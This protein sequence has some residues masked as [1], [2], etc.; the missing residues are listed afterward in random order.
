MFMHCFS[1]WPGEASQRASG[2]AFAAN[3]TTNWKMCTT[4]SCRRKCYIWKNFLIGRQKRAT[5]GKQIK[6]IRN[7]TVAGIAQPPPFWSL[8]RASYLVGSAAV[9]RNKHASSYTVRCAFLPVLFWSP[10]AH[11]APATSAAH[12]ACIPLSHSLCC[13]SQTASTHK[14]FSAEHF[15]SYRMLLD[16]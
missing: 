5:R 16:Y 9:R 7:P 12:K 4:R 1:T 2:A 13:W 8:V 14:S 3:P 11:G 15:Q 10:Y 6:I